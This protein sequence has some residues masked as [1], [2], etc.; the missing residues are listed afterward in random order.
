MPR[1]STKEGRWEAGAIQK[2]ENKQGKILWRSLN[3]KRQVFRSNYTSRETCA[4]EMVRDCPS[5]V[6]TI[7]YRKAKLAQR[8]LDELSPEARAA[9]LPLA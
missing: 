7:A 8:P 9:R 2:Y 6:R 1:L 4:Q 3:L 5:V